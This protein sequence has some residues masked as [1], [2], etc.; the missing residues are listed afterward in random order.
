[1][2][3]GMK[4]NYG[5]QKPALSVWTFS[6]PR[7]GL[8]QLVVQSA[9][10]PHRSRYEQPGSNAIKAAWFWELRR[11][12]LRPIVQCIGRCA[13][14]WAANKTWQSEVLRLGMIGQARLNFVG[15]TL[16][17]EDLRERLQAD[18]QAVDRSN[19]A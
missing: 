14:L 17:A 2:L 7:D 5:P 12:R 18:K 13:D 19:S 8:V 3:A 11:L 16:Q 10:R 4:G 9:H 6:D 15:N 1:M